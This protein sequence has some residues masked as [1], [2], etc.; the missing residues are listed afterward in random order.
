M[1]KKLWLGA[2][3]GLFGMAL[4]G[5]V[6]LGTGLPGQMTNSPSGQ[7]SGGSTDTGS[8]AVAAQGP[9]MISAKDP[10][11]VSL[12][13]GIYA[14]NCASCH[15]ENLEGEPNWRQ[16]GIDGLLP[17]PPHDET[18]HTWHHADGLL[19]EITKQGPA[20]LAGNNYQSAMPGYGDVLKDAEIIAV[21]AYIKSRW[22]KDVQLQQAEISQKYRSR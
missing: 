16:R 18:G 21:L 17:A 14:E 1:K 10:L 12:G 9:L 22:P 8:T 15:G 19:F 6:F 4:L 3:V 7:T 11:L 5:A 20:A 2:A 13:S